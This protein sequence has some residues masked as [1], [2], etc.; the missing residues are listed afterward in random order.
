MMMVLLALLAFGTSEQ[1][2]IKSVAKEKLVL[3]TM[4]PG[5]DAVTRFG[6]AALCVVSS[7]Q[8]RGECFN[9]GHTTTSNG[10][11]WHI[12][13]GKA[14][15]FVRR[16]S[17]GELFAHYKNQNR[18]VWAQ[19]VSS[20]PSLVHAARE[21]MLSDSRSNAA[22]YRYDPFAKNCTTRVRNILN[23]V[24]HGQ[25]YATTQQLS[26]Q[27]YRTSANLIVDKTLLGTLAMDLVLG[28]EGDQNLTKWRSMYLPRNLRHAL[29]EL[30][31]APRLLSSAQ[32]VAFEEE[33]LLSRTQSLL[34]W[35]GTLTLLILLFKTRKLRLLSVAILAIALA[36]AGAAL[37]AVLLLSSQSLAWPNYT[38]LVLTPLDALLIL[39]IRQ[40]PPRWLFCYGWARV[41][42]CTGV[43]VSM[44]T[45][46]IPQPLVPVSTL[47]VL[48]LTYLIVTRR[49]STES[50]LPK[51]CVC[52]DTEAPTSL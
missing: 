40:A 2:S 43:L 5:T 14:Q 33:A 8:R 28:P 41:L 3:L 46:Q 29:T 36:G 51:L 52:N 11:R 7:V 37:W 35:F 15:F 20:D 45:G 25:L 26:G 1:E 12:L 21:R 10:F 4:S 17:F 50:K 6:H 30:G 22:E 34:F 31:F 19:T 16:E 38:I 48:A 23:T 49:S 42:L 24:L 13:T 44:L 32:P 18:A 39:L 9:Y 47:V 27:T